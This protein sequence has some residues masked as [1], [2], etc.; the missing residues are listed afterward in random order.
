MPQPVTFRRS[1]LKLRHITLHDTFTSGKLFGNV[2]YKLFANFKI[3]SLPHCICYLVVFQLSCNLFL[4][5]IARS[6]K[7]IVQ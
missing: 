7:I 4:M 2:G 1:R 5:Y 6:K 3:T